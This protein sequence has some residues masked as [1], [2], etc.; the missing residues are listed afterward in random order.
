MGHESQER[1]MVRRYFW[2]I[3]Q[4]H[5][6]NFEY[7]MTVAG[8]SDMHSFRSSNASSY[9]IYT[10]CMACFLYH[11]LILCGMNMSHNIEWMN[12]LVDL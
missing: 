2:L 7:C 12:G 5:L 10:K 6:K 9:T 4:K 8:S 3:E 1:S 11:T